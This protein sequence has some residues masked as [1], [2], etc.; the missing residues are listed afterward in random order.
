MKIIIANPLLALDIQIAV[1]TEE[2]RYY[3]N[4]FHAEKAKEGLLL[5]STDGHRM[6][7][8]HDPL[9]SI[10]GETGPIKL[11]PWFLKQIKPQL[12]AATDNGIKL[13]IEGDA[14]ESKATLTHGNGTELINVPDVIIDGTFPDWRRVVPNLDLGSPF[15]S[16]S[17]N[18]QYLASFG[19]L[20]RDRTTYV[21]TFGNKDGK[22]AHIVKISGRHDVVGVLM[23]GRTEMSATLPSWMQDAVIEKVETP[24]DH[25]AA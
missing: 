21:Q 19:K 1:S 22:N 4:G 10:E 3:I 16:A 7:I 17:F 13:C 5:V 24:N 8:I 11:P 15:I 14:T 23:P 12:K 9:G 18:V 20:S 6:L 25:V 2:T